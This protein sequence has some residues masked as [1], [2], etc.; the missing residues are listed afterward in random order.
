LIQVKQCCRVPLYISPNAKAGQDVSGRRE[1]REGAMTE[2]S[3]HDA[4]RATRLASDAVSQVIKANRSGLYFLAGARNVLIDELLFA[5]TAFVDRAVSEAH[6]FNEVLSKMA[7]AHSVKDLGAMSV[8]C[9][10]HQ[11]DFIRRDAERLFK[12]G[13]RMIDNTSKLIDAV[14]EPA[15]DEVRPVVGS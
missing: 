9:T 8:E 11:L 6:L 14:A 4:T 10:R 3:E 2:L 12:H 13:E 15:L 5:G 7:G 1:A